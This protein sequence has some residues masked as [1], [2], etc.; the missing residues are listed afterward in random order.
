MKSHKHSPTNPNSIKAKLTFRFL[1]AMKKLNK[2]I[3]PSLSSEDKYKRY[4]AIRIA[5]Y[6]SMAFA[7]GMHK[8]WSRA[9]LRKMITNH[10]HPMKK[11]QKAPHHDGKNVVITRG[12]PRNY[13]GELGFGPENDL[14]KLV[15]G[16][17]G[18]DICRLLN[19]TG[20]YIK[21][22]KAQVKVMRKIVDFSSR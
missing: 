4:H 11:R 6:E 15:P 16:G 10:R 20:D 3:P 13:G 2:K 14:R 7:V 21:C 18:M 22:L 17:K 9:L 19:E 5:A 12:N 8:A 1:Q